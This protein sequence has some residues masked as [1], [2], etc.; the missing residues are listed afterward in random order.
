MS[1]LQ[2]NNY[3][4][5]T[6]RINMH[7]YANIAPNLCSNGNPN[8]TPSCTPA[9]CNAMPYNYY[10]MYDDGLPD[11]E[12]LPPPNLCQTVQ[13]LNQDKYAYSNYY[14]YS[15]M[16]FQDPSVALN[17]T[18]TRLVSNIP[19]FAPYTD[20]KLSIPWGII[21]IDDIIWVVNSGSGIV[22]SYHLQGES[23]PQ[24][25]NVFGPLGNITQPTGIAY[26]TNINSFIIVNGQLRGSSSLI[27]VTRDGT[28]NGYNN[29]IRP[30]SSVLLVDRSCAK[31]VYTGV[32][33]VNTAITVGVSLPL[34]KQY[35]NI[36]VADFY[37]HRID[38]FD[39]KLNHLN[40]QTICDQ[41]KFNDEDLLD[42]IPCDYAPYN[43]V[44]IGDYLY[45]TYARQNCDDNQYEFLGTGH[46]Y[47]NIFTYDGTYVKRFVSNGALNAPWGLIL[48][49]SSF[50][51]PAGSIMVSN[52]GDGLINIY[53]CDGA[54]IGVLKDNSNN[55]FCL[56][57]LH[58]LALNCR[59]NKIIYWTLTEDN[60]RNSY[61]GSIN[62]ACLCP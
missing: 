31:S 59:Y 13:D 14:D 6:M 48:A 45:V 30:N 36:Y 34:I 17:F 52:Y 7:R 16:P 49:P 25:I 33:I 19:T 50:G 60:L 24:I 44:N 11:P 20:C 1:Y 23:F 3:Y 55:P 51:Y 27:I 43:I 29:A 15:T 53:N 28:I 18:I 46:G 4:N 9:P 35:N 10:Y 58:G 39:G 5:K 37:N 2:Y 21:V 8:L 62:A 12:M 56:G 22:T 38:V 57:G 41:Y 26:N 61:V 47:I 32:A 42:P 40:G 54:Y